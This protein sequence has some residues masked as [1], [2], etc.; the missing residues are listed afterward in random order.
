MART[1]VIDEAQYDKLVEIAR[2]LG[3]ETGKLI[4][5]QGK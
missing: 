2:G 5:R 4:R 3:F 1:P